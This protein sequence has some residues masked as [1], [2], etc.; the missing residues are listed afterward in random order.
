MK[1]FKVFETAGLTLTS[2]QDIP[3][4]ALL[5]PAG[6]TTEIQVTDKRWRK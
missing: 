5:E 2:G 3:L 4:D 1:G 6:E